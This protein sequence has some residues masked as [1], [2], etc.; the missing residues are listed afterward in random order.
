MCYPTTLVTR[1]SST[2]GLHVRCF[3]Y[4]RD[5]G[6]VGQLPT[7]VWDLRFVVGDGVIYC[8][9]SG[10][11]GCRAQRSSQSMLEYWTISVMARGQ[12]PV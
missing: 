6:C 10:R 5:S 9:Q 8:G 4:L 11:S 12:M 7:C 2:A 3:I 1:T